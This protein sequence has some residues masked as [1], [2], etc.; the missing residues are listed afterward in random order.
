MTKSHD[1]QAKGLD[2]ELQ[3]SEFMRI[4]YLSHYMH[5]FT[6]EP[7]MYSYLVGPGGLNLA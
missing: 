2:N 6:L 5:K 7:C 4:W 1:C 3:M